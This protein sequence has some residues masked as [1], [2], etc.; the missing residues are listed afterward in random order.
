MGLMELWKY[1]VRSFLQKSGTILYFPFFVDSFVIGFAIVEIPSIVISKKKNVI[2]S[3]SNLV[4][5]E[6]DHT[7]VSL[8]AERLAV[9]WKQHCA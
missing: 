2:S 3:C 5:N 9:F 4:S 1:G 7:V 6:L 8:A